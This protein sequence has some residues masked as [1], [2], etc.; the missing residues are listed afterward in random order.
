MYIKVV[1]NKLYITLYK[2][3][4]NIGMYG[5]CNHI[6]EMC[7]IEYIKQGPYGIVYPFIRHCF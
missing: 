6:V 1:Q 2:N 7:T 3:L 4:N 5:L